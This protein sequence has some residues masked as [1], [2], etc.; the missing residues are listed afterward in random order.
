MDKEILNHYNSSR[1]AQSYARKFEKH[2]SERINNRH[3]QR[4]LE[5]LMRAISESVPFE[6]A[7]DLPCG[8]GR[9]MPLLKRHARRVIEGDWSLPLLRIARENQR[10]DAAIHMADG[11]VR[12]TALAMPFDDQAFDVVLSV[13]LCHH[14]RERSERLNYVRE[15]LRISGKWVIFTYFDYH[16][17]KNQLREARRRFFGKRPKWTLKA[18]EV[19][20]IAEDMGFEVV[21]SVPLS[22]LFSGHRYTALRRKSTGSK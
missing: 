20:E 4:L 8:Y 13:R 11:Y 3:E 9:L 7:L 15:L 14:I 2:W 12:A 19:A 22:R 6:R 17:I 21:Y 1:G 16:S 18:T 10:K 5:R